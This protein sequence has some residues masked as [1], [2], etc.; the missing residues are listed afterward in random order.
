[1]ETDRR[2]YEGTGTAGKTTFMRYTYDNYGNVT[3]YFDA[4]DPGTA[5]DVVGTI[6]YSSCPTTYVVGTPTKIS[7]KTPDV[8]GTELRHREATVDCSTGNVTQ[9]REYLADGSNA[10]SDLTYFPNGNLQTV[11]GPANLHGQ[12]YQLTYAYDP[13]V[14]TFVSSIKDSFGYTSTATYNPAYGAPASTTDT[15]NN[16]TGYTYDEFGR[17]ATIT[18]PY[19]QGGST[20]TVQFEYHPNDPVPWAMTRNLDSY[21]GPGATIDTVTFTDGLDRVIQTKKTAAIFTGANSSPQDVM[22]VS[23]RITFDFLGRIVEQYYPVTEPL[24][25]PGS[26]NSTYDTVQ[27]TR[28][29]YDILDRVTKTTKPDNTTVTN[30]YGFGL[31]RSG[32]TQFLMTETDA[33]GNQ[34]KTYE[35]VRELTTGVER[36]LTSGSSTQPVWT[37]YAYDPMQQMVS[38]TDDQNNVTHV[39]YDNLGRR[40]SI[41]NPNTGR[42]DT[43]Y[44]LASNVTAR[45]TAN[46]RKQGTQ[47]SYD[48]DFTRLKS[49]TYPNF[50]GNDVTY[51]YGAP[52]APNNGAGRA[53]QITDEA[54]SVQRSYGKLGEVTREVATINSKTQGNGPNSS[55]VYTTQYVYDTWGRLQ[56]LTYPDGEVLTYQYDSGG[57]VR[58][59]TG[60]KLGNMYRYVKRYEYDKFGELVFIQLG[61]GVTTQYTY[62]ADNRRLANLRSITPAGT[63]FQSLN[64]SYD[65]VG[66]ILGEANA[67]SV[68]APS[69]MGG[70]TAQTFN[71]DSLYRLTSA[72]GTYQFA[73]DKTRQ[74]SLNMSY[75]SIDNILSK[76]QTDAITQ[77][78]GTSIP[79]KK[80]SYAFTY[81]YQGA[82]P[83]APTH[84][85]IRT[86]TYDA[87]GNQTGWDDDKNGT[88]RTIIWDE[89]NRIQAIYDNGHKTSYLYDDTGN[90]ILKYGPHGQTAYVNPFFTIRN[91]EIGTKHIWIGTTRV[92]SKLM[93]NPDAT[94]PAPV[95]RVEYYFHPDQIGSSNYI[96]EADGQIFQH[97]EYFPFGETWVE[98]KS[99]T[100]N[101]P[102]LYAAKELDEETDLYYYGARYY[103]PR[104]SVWQSADPALYKYLPQR[105]GGQAETLPAQ[106]G[107]YM[108]GNLNLYDY[109]REN[110]VQYTDPS[111]QW[112]SKSIP[113]IA[114]PVH[115]MAVQNVLGGQVDVRWVRLMQQR[116][117]EM[118][119]AQAPQDQYLHAMVGV[120]GSRDEAI[121]LANQFVHDRVAAAQAE[122]KDGNLPQAYS[123]L[124][125]AI[126]TVTDATSPVHRGF[127]TYDP[128]HIGF[129]E[130]TYGALKHGLAESTYPAEGTPER[131]ELEGGIRYLYDLVR[132]PTSPIPQTFF[133]KQTGFLILP[134][135]YRPAPVD[136]TGGPTG[137]GYDSL[138]GGAPPGG[139]Q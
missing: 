53:V 19:E 136:A 92:V 12:R 41:D 105:P 120:G 130:Y 34:T 18:G 5:D 111:G 8:N 116:Q 122:L 99:N 94:D 52:G 84:I 79:Q 85:G 1:V 123:D 125:D 77:P 37:S 98:E 40:T 129:G 90:R 86:Y 35:N 30:S 20:P 11:T 10:V 66:N 26:F 50:P 31:D 55:E 108:P 131:A 134:P 87:N 68:P 83:N 48:Y 70:P 76:T 119:K 118:D 21:R 107:V 7:V 95:E 13:D 100:Q 28:T 39:A 47:I 81:L 82:Q 128:G 135:Q 56:N 6:S 91:R 63:A 133:D 4:G 51:T 117:V 61:N 54:G 58:Q 32:A 74:Y 102:Y 43:I 97:L 16:P 73:P 2:F 60:L 59:A 24:G 33:N 17:V 88:R 38:V 29:T 103:D 64:F 22:V 65:N 115:Q 14:Q 106:G 78:S 96:T 44:D 114:Q 27:P 42:T 139:T 93:K 3:Q 49:I 112:S 124:G 104:T 46:L 72:S 9:V 121:R 57:R 110:P 75:D 113:L 23:G 137:S 126:H 127:Q 89:E 36:F 62:R 138:D 25:A 132:N 69:Q 15:N 67:V 80:T 45:I 109:V 71:Y 101:T